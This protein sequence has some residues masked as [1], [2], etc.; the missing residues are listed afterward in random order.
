MEAA[1]RV[2]NTDTERMSGRSGYRFA[3]KDMRQRVNLVLST[4]RRRD[5]PADAFAVIHL[6]SMASL[7]SCC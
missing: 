4:A 7:R 3:D 5:H 6:R 1:A 2:R